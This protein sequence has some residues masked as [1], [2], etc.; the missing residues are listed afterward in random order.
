M[1]Q[2]HSLL[3][4][5]KSSSDANL[6]SEEMEEDFVSLSSSSVISGSGS[7]SI[8]GRKHY[9]ESSSSSATES[10]KRTKVDR[11]Q[12]SWLKRWP[13]LVFDEDHGMFYK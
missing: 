10:F 11:F 6:T 7:E 13:W 8:S 2:Q 9:L 12:S 1:A 3:S 5:V 4:F